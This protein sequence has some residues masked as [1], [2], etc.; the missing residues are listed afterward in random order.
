[1]LGEEEIAL[2]VRL[3]E[4]LIELAE[5]VAQRLDLQPLIGDLLRV[6][7]TERGEALIALERRARKVVLF[8]VHGQLGFP[9]PL[10]GLVFLLLLLLFQHVLVGHRDGDLR[11]HLQQLILHVENHLLQHLLRILRAVDEI[12]EVRADERRDAFKNSHD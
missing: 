3:G 10:R 12:V 2:G 5:R 4:F 8:F 11:L 7:F 9:H 1:M 6:A